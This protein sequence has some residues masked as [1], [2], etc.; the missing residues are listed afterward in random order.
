MVSGRPQQRTANEGFSI[1]NPEG[2]GLRATYFN[3]TNFER[4]IYSRVDEEIDFHYNKNSPAPGVN[5]QHYSICWTGS[6][7]APVTGTYRISVRVDDGVR[8][9]LNGVKVLDKWKTQKATTYT[10]QMHLT[11]AEFYQI[12]I[13]Y[14][15]GQNEG[16]IQ[17]LWELPM[18]ESN[19]SSAEQRFASRR[20]IPKQYL[21]SELPKEKPALAQAKQQKNV[22][23][24]NAAPTAS[25]SEK[26]K[27]TVNLNSHN[28]SSSV[29]IQR[30]SNNPSEG[31]EY[32]KLPAGSTFDNLKSGELVPL[33]EVSFE[34]EKWVLK[35][36]SYAELDKLARTL[37]RY[38][39]LKIRIEVYTDSFE[40]PNINERM[41]L[42]RAKV[43]ATYLQDSGIDL[44][45]MELKGTGSNQLT[46]ENLPGKGTAAN[47]YVQFVVK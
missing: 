35:E 10:G 45:R 33:M 24:T 36:T 23:N 28:S 40:D 4:R 39:D 14:F 1:Q 43:I 26:S 30:M 44:A 34:P 20:P 3:G 37:K 7:Y 46:A 19:S 21:F 31:V 11:A 38:P 17:L 5:R 41:S 13:E 22:A 42:Y 12:R 15:N 8:M 32:E 9:W 18:N 6:L 27:Q 2:D 25:A 16:I 29:S 47:K